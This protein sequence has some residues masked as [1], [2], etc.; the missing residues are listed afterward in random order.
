MIK[1][2]IPI[3]IL[4][5]IRGIPPGAKSKHNDVYLLHFNQQTILKN[6]KEPQC[7]D[8][9]EIA[10]GKQYSSTWI[11]KEQCR[12]FRAKSAEIK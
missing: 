4:L 8:I 12:A 10:S 5:K 9:C 3:D 6:Y 7:N 11:E 2:E 1:D